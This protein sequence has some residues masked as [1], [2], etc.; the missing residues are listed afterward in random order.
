MSSQRDQVAMEDSD[1]VC[2]EDFTKLTDLHDMAAHACDLL[3]AMANEWRLIILCHLA[4]GEKTVSELQGLLGL[5]QSA[6]SQHLAILR[7]EKIVRARKHAQSV[8][9]SLSGDEAT[10]VM[11][12]LHEVF[13]SRS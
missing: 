9:Y 2:P 13:C 3:K 8:S 7:R 1:A 6:L 10:K 11:E 5:S 12:T 4:E